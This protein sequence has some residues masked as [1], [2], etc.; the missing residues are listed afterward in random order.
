MCIR[1]GGGEGRGG[2]FLVQVRKDNLKFQLPA[3]CFTQED[4]KNA[5]LA[6]VN[7]ENGVE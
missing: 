5:T 7:A 1:K 3:R 4:K 6:T 2:A